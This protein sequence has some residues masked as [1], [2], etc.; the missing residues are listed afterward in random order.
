MV[1]KPPLAAARPPSAEPLEEPPSDLVPTGASLAGAIPAAGGVSVFAN[2]SR[3][4]VLVTFTAEAGAGA[5]ITVL[6][7]ARVGAIS[8]TAGSYA[9]QLDPQET[10]TIRSAGGQG[11][12]RFRVHSVKSRCRQ[13]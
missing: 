9:G 11:A 8:R 6:Y 1:R 7:G 10:L 12:G 13:L 3:D 4:P 2:H 5:T